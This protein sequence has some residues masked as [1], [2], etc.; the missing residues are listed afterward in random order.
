MKN[1][2]YRLF[3]N[4][5]WEKALKEANNLPIIDNKEQCIGYFKECPDLLYGNTLGLNISILE[6]KNGVITHCK[7]NS[8]S[9]VKNDD[10]DSDNG[11]YE[12]INLS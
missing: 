1:K 9:L 5:V 4:G 12:L 2:N 10:L 11:E 8:I 6:E 7:I 3:E